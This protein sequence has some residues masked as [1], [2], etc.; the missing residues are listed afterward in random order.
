M[1]KPLDWRKVIALSG[2]GSSLLRGAVDRI[3]AD[4]AIAGARSTV[5]VLLA[6]GPQ[7]RPGLAHAPD[8]PAVYAYA[9]RIVA[10]IAG[11]ARVEADAPLTGQAP[12]ATIELALLPELGQSTA[13]EIVA[14]EMLLTVELRVTGGSVAG[15]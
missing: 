3:D 12:G 10:W 5:A 14:R 4:V 11:I 1:R 9:V 8:A 15:Q 6:G 7:R 13:D 2:R